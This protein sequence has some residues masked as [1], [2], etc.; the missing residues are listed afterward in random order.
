MMMM[1]AMFPKTRRPLKVIVVRPVIRMMLPLTLAQ[2]KVRLALTLAQ[3]KVRPIRML[4][5]MIPQRFNA[6]EPRP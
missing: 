5:L 4:M 1:L 2:M 3:M 6:V